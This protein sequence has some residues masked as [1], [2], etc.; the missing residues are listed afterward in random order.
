[1]FQII[2]PDTNYDFAGKK[3]FF[4]V[5]SAV[6]VLASIVLFFTKGLNYGIDFT[7]GAE[8]HV[9]VPADWDTGKV[10]DTLETGGLPDARVQSI[11]DPADH[12]FMIKAQGDEGSL[13]QVS[14][15][16]RE[17]LAA[18]LDAGQFDILRAEVVGPA[19]GKSLRMRGFLSMLYA[20]LAILLYVAIRFDIRYSPGAVLSLFHDA[21]VVIGVFVITG[22]QFDLTILAAILA[23][24][25]YSIN[26]TI[27]IYDRV[28]EVLHGDPG[29][30]IDVAVNR[31]VN[32]TLS[33]S[34]L[35]SLT[36]FFSVFALWIMGGKVLE[37]FAFALMIGV[38]VGAYS[39]IFVASAMVIIT[40]QYIQKRASSKTSSGSSGKKRA[41]YVR[42]EPKFQD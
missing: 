12:Q 3:N 29:M 11:G 20:L 18:K 33:R 1:M 15:K 37:D 26:D 36:T 14:G 17:A 25:G 8:V 10:R 21:I 6:T 31:A 23:L 4:L 7:G 42:P 35:T 19:A 24:I 9:Q 13:N 28:R 40:T 34:I 27:V 32:E 16:V 2:K 5:L 38:I 41:V 39:T 30:K 22:K